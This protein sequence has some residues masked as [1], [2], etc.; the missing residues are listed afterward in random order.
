[1]KRLPSFSS[2]TFTHSLI[3]L[4][5]LAALAALCGSG[6]YWLR[7]FAQPL[8]RP[9]IPASMQSPHRE[10]GRAAARLFGDSPF[11][12][13]ATIRLTGVLGAKQSTAGSWQAVAVVRVSNAAPVIVAPGATLMP[14]VILEQVQQSA[15]LVRSAGQTHEIRLSPSPQPAQGWL[16]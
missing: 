13:L 1:M 15:I 7:M 3:P 4:L 10:I 6:V 16:R 12:P 11:D 2:I 5:S 8:T 9:V 14:G